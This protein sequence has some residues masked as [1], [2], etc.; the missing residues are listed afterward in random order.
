MKHVMNLNPGPFAMTA[1]GKKTF[2]LRLLDEK[3]RQ[4]AVGDSIL[5]VHT[6]DA[7]KTLSCR[8]LA[9]HPFPNFEALYRTLPLEK[10]GYLPEEVPGASYTDM[11][12]YYPK[13]KQAQYGVIAIELALE[14][15]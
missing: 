14:N 2:E 3:R 12:A 4:I 8:V 1:C 9:L 7:D 6:E 15:I 13:E 10:C 5:F 11:E